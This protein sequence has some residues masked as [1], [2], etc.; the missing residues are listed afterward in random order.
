[1]ISEAIQDVQLSDVICSLCIVYRGFYHP[2]I[3]GSQ[4]AIIRIPI[5]QSSK[6]ECHTGFERYS[7]NEHSQDEDSDG[8]G[9]A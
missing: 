3:Q 8:D 2:V 6:M 1:M 9:L 4:E 5:D 7:T